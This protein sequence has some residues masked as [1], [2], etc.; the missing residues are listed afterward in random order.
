MA[1]PS[2]VKQLQDMINEVEE[3]EH[4]FGQL[5][6]SRMF[7]SKHHIR[8]HD[9]HDILEFTFLYCIALY[10]MKSDVIVGPVASRYAEHTYLPGPFTHFTNTSTDLRLFLSLIYNA[11]GIADN[12][13]STDYTSGQTMD[14]RMVG[15]YLHDI[16]K[17][18][19]LSHWD[20]QFLYKMEGDYR[21]GN[22]NYRSVRRLVIDWEKIPNR[23]KKLV[24]TRLLQAFRSRMPRSE[25]LPYLEDMT[26]RHDW[27]L[28]DVNNPETGEEAEGKSFLKSLAARA[29]GFAAG[30][31][32]IRKMK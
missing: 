20:K 15:R 6:E 11:D 31:A 21:I 25:L 3:E 4:F 8:Q 5:Y 2:F 16:A 24:M 10:V 29:A 19:P 18:G 13:S 28:K 32:A 9:I 22:S 30:Y 12:L 1:D 7:P 17:A 26:E 23:D 14:Q 27:E